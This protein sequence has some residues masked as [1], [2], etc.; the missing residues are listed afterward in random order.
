MKVLADF[1]KGFIIT[2][3]LGRIVFYNRIQ[4]KIADLVPPDVLGEKVTGIYEL[5]TDTSIIFRCL[6]S[7]LPEG[8]WKVTVCYNIIWT[9]ESG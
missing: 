6:N 5:D 9:I 4:G 7:G 2:D 1:D 3:R 8:I